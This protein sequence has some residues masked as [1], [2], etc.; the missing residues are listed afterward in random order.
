MK[1]FVAI[2]A[3]IG[4]SQNLQAGISSFSLPVQKII[5]E[6]LCA[7]NPSSNEVVDNHDYWVDEPRHDHHRDK[8]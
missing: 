2:P 8:G 6:A 7:T 4:G 1:T 3:G 5:G